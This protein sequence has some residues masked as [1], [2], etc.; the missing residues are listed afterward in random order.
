MVYESRRSKRHQEDDEIDDDLDHIMVFML[1]EY[2]MR[3]S[4]DERK[5]R[6]GSV[7]GHEVYDRSR[8]DERKYR[9]ASS[10]CHCSRAS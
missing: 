9:I 8:G 5:K 10:L 3:K 2:R 1:G 4:G 7:F 6:R